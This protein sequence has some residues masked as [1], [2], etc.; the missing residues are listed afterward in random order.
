MK[1]E[2]PRPDA[3]IDSAMLDLLRCPAT[4]SRLRVVQAGGGFE[5]VAEG[6][7]E[8]PRYPVV[9]GIPILLPPTPPP[10]H[11]SARTGSGPV[12]RNREN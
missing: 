1:S 11:T 9:N 3:G 6:G 5:L 8:A 4:G 10:P 7:P 2:P 12:P